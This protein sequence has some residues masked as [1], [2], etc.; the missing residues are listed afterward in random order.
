MI[1]FANPAQAPTVSICQLVKIITFVLS[2]FD[3]MEMNKNEITINC[4]YL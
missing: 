2:L 3:M 1:R 4:V